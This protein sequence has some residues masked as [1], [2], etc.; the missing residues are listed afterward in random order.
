[1]RKYL[2]LW[3]FLLISVLAAQD[4]SRIDSVK[5]ETAKAALKTTTQQNSRPNWVAI[6]AL[7]VAFGG[8]LFSI[9]TH[10]SKKKLQQELARIKLKAEDDFAK[11]KQDSASRQAQK[12]AEEILCDALTE[13]LGSIRLLG[14]PEI[15]NLPVTLLRSFVNLR[16]SETYRSETRVA[17]GYLRECEPCDSDLSPSEIFQRA[18]SKFRMLLII[19]DPGSGKTTLLKYFAM[20]IL[21]G[22]HQKLGVSPEILPLYLPLREL[23]P[24]DSLSENLAQWAKRHEHKISEDV[25]YDWLHHRKTLLLLDGLDE[26]SHLDQ[27]RAVCRWID[28]RAAGLKHAWFVVTSRWTGYSKLN[29]I[30]LGFDHLR[31]D[32]KD[33]SWEQQ[34]E[35]L[36]KWFDAVAQVTLP[37]RNAPADWQARQ[38]KISQK[39]AREIIQYLD[40]PENEAV[41]KLAASPMLLQ[42]IAILGKERAFQATNRAELYN[43]ALNYLLDLRDRKRDL[44]PPLRAKE[45][46]TVLAPTALW[47]QETIGRDD[48]AR[49]K[50]HDFMQ[51]IIEPIDEKL[52]AET[53]CKNLCDRAGILVETGQADYLFRHKSF[54]EYL[55]GLQLNKQARDQKYLQQLAAHFNDDWWEEPLRFF[56]GEATA[57]EFDAFMDILFGAEV[58]QELD[59]KAQNRLQQLI[60]DAPAKKID[61]LVRRLKDDRLNQNQQR[62]ILE[63]LKNI[64][65]TAAL[66]QI[67]NYAETATET[68]NVRFARGISFAAATDSATQK[69][70]SLN[71]FQDLPPSFF[72]SREENA[73]YILIPGGTYRFSVTGKD[74]MVPPTYFARYPVT[75]K[76]YGLFM[77]YLKQ[78]AELTAILPFDFFVSELRKLAEKLLDFKKYLPENPREWMDKFCSKTDDKK[79]LGDDQPVV[80]VTWYDTQAYCC[81][82]TLMEAFTTGSKTSVYFRLPHEREWEWTAAGREPDGSLREYPWPKAKGKPTVKLANYGRNVGTTTPVGRYPDGATPEGLLDMVGNVWEWQANRYKNDSAALGL[83]G[84]SWGSHE[85]NLRCSARLDLDPFNL[86]NNGGFRVVLSESRAFENLEL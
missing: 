51:P 15:R 81:W 8:L 62:Y 66:E 80:Q 47:M 24:A 12:S 38:L 77:A 73:E 31:A 26:I 34:Q 46:R 10:F 65:T 41:R 71:V 82:L 67:R 85:S 61:A 14:S 27:R 36:K 9:Y 16:I 78:Q 28:D 70:V 40:K 3:I 33:F 22:D 13:E 53:F 56:M 74:V 52:A 76:R 17:E 23:N 44:P 49:E 11:E 43:A 59:Q 35:F 39:Q 55:C 75:N 30:Q 1:M 48:V 19:G 58:T 72:N 84:G 54:R 5:S 6:G 69:R 50:M 4:S 68:E 83:R 42:I 63:S 25:F 18:F 32:I 45:A 79:F 20:T 57:E 2:F 7:A 37:P 60:K 21:N 64:G 86:W 29:G